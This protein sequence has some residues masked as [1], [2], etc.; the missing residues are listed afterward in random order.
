MVVWADEDVQPQRRFVQSN[1]SGKRTDLLFLELLQEPLQNPPA[2]AQ[3]AYV[4][5]SI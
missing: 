4:L 2:L 3:T 1:P 5:A